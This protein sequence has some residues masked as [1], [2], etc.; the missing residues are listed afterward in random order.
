M[1][2]WNAQAIVGLIVIVIA[3]AAVVA[4]PGLQYRA[5]RELQ[6]GWRVA[7]FLPLA[8]MAVVVAVTVPA[9]FQG[10]NLWPIYLIF[11]TPF[12]AVYLLALRA[13]HRRVSGSHD[14]QGGA[15]V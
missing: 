6:G 5:I 14:S 2:E 15:R 13:A 3:F 12:A 11:I 4:Y 1:E 7:A 9:I 8:V 10:S